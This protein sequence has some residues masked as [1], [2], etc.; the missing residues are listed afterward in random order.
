MRL[1]G[2]RDGV[3]FADVPG[4]VRHEEVL[5]ETTSSISPL[6]LV[7]KVPSYSPMGPASL[8]N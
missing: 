7:M 6:S 8:A 5:L 3:K 2:A 1:G 4:L